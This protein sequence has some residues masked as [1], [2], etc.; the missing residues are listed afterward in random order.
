MTTGKRQKLNLDLDSLFPGNTVAIGTSVAVIKPLSIKQI[1]T[2]AKKIKGIAGI[3]SEADITWDNF[4]KADKLVDLIVILLDNCPEVI[5]EATNIDIDD[6]NVMPIE[7]VFEIINAAVNV[8]LESK[9]KLEGNLKSLAEKFSN[10]VEATN[11]TPTSQK[12][13]KD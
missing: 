12:Q 13:S 8:N 6:I 2:L 1:A 4:Q 11:P 5:E 3:L 7:L 10:L 9:E